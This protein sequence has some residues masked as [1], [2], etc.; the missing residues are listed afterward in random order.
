VA[1]FE[2][3]IHTKSGDIVNWRSNGNLVGER[4]VDLE[5]TTHK[6][7]FLYENRC[8]ERISKH[9]LPNQVAI[10]PH[11]IDHIFRDQEWR[12]FCRPDGMVFSTKNS[13]WTLDALL[14]IKTTDQDM[15][16]KLFGFYR[17]LE[18][19]QARPKYFKSALHELLKNHCVQPPSWINFPRQHDV[20]VVLMEPF[21]GK[22]SYYEQSLFP[23]VYFKVR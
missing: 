7:E 14:E 21:Y 4:G 6:D 12:N 16:K 15:K 20:T 3:S 19:L 13:T 9:L 1:Q 5:I 17:L 11:L 2:Y 8:F 10:G 23:L 22:A 18:D